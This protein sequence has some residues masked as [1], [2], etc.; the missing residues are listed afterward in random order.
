M[1][2]DLLCEK[3][4]QET[5]RWKIKISVEGADVGDVINL[6]DMD[7]FIDGLGKEKILDFIGEESCIKHFG[8]RVAEE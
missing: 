1:D 6:I 3:A 2:F 4:S 7:G 8:I 5:Y